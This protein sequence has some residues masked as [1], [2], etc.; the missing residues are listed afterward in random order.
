P[1]PAR[2]RELLEG[3][4]PEPEQ[5]E[6]SRHLDT[7]VNCQNTLENLAAGGVKPV[8][9][10]KPEGAVESALARVMAQ[11]KGDSSEA[12]T[13]AGPSGRPETEL[14]FLSPT[15]QPGSLGKLGPYEVH[16]VLGR[17]GMGVVL[18][19]FEAS[20]ARHVAI[21]VLAPHLATAETNRKRFLRE[22]R[23]AAA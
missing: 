13:Q 11:L 1:E 15:E 10:R 22:A 16:E 9:Q 7:C 20:L 17:G 12:V 3:A 14:D 8:G 23:A 21:K 18:K 19:A 6:V 4:L 5:A 2:L